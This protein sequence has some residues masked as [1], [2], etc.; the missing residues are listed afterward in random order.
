MATKQSRF[1]AGNAQV[2]FATSH[3]AGSVVT[4]VA[5]IDL[6]AGLLAADVMEILP[7]LPNGRI[8]AFDISDIGSLLGTTN[9]NIGMMTGNPGDT[10]AV[11][12]VGTELVSAQAAGTIYASTLAQLAA[13]PRNA[14]TPV[15]I[16]LKVSA[17]VVA[18]AGKMLHV[19]YS[20][21]A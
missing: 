5:S 8:V 21:V 19:R 16:G 17:N 11:R 12:T 15:S 13:I 6:S 20:Y 10:T 14:G 4:V 2:P 9:I 3:K 1:Y 7:V 18:G